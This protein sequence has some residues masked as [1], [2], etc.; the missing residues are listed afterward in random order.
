MLTVLKGNQWG[1]LCRKV[2]AAFQC[3]STWW[4]TAVEQNHWVRKTSCRIAV[5]SHT[6]A[7]LLYLGFFCLFLRL[8]KFLTFL[9]FYLWNFLYFLN[10]FYAIFFVS[11]F[12]FTSCVFSCLL[13]THLVIFSTVH[14]FL[15][16]FSH[17]ICL[18]NMAKEVEKLKKNYLLLTMF[19]AYSSL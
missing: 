6:F 11:Y 15:F 9:L 3:G 14:S 19:S 5:G 8:L 4:I 10:M 13:L 16:T 18:K 17:S 2:C 7:L 12:F 1:S